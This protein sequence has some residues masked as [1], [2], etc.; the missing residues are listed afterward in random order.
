MLD[1]HQVMIGL[2]PQSE[3]SDDRVRDPPDYRPVDH[4]DDLRCPPITE[5]PV[6]VNRTENEDGQTPYGEPEYDAYPCSLRC[7]P[8]HSAP[9]IG[10]SRSSQ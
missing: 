10:E 5:I 9:P 8:D 6:A 7:C 3:D 2:T 4:F 1:H